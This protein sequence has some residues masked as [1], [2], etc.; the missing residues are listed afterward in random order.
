MTTKAGDKVNVKAVGMMRVREAQ[1][2]GQVG[3]V[4]CLSE[5]F[6]KT[7]E[8]VGAKWV[9]EEEAGSKLTGEGECKRRT[10]ILEFSQTV[11]FKCD[12][13]SV[14]LRKVRIK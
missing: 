4:Q 13:V 10:A 11:L 6:M 8:A 9:Q 2:I 3:G 1:E 5:P 12:A 14:L 7:Q